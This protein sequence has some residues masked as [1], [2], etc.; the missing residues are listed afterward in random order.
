MSL[1]SDVRVESLVSG[2][3]FGGVS[4]DGVDGGED[5]SGRNQQVRIEEKK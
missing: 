5:G 3:V 4:G 2:A 1:P